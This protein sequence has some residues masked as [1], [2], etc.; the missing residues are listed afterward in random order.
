MNTTNSSQPDSQPQP[1]PKAPRR[2]WRRGAIAAGLVAGGF[3]LGAVSLASAQGMAYGDHW[4]G[5]PWHGARIG[6]FQHVVRGALENVGATTAQEDKIH[7][8]VAAT[9]TDLDQGADGRA[10]LRKQVLDLLRAP[11]IDRAAVEKLRADQIA[12]IDAKSKRVVQAVLDVSAQLTPDQR[13][14]LVREAE[15]R[16]EHRG[17]GGMHRGEPMDGQDGPTPDGGHRAPGDHG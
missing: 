15:D 5:G 7:D 3:A 8:I 12:A 4:Q 14:K 11:T 9:F 1:E 16:M 10:A 17:W 6:F 13:T 2:I